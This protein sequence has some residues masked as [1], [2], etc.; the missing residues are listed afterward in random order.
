MKDSRYDKLKKAFDKLLKD[1]VE[2][3]N[4]CKPDFPKKTMV[5]FKNDWKT[6]AG[7]KIK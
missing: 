2:V 7:L 6:E 4:L 5:E 1:H 3:I